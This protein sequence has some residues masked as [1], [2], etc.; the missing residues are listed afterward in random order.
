M[1]NKKKYILTFNDI[2]NIACSIFQDEIKKIILNLLS[3]LVKM[4]IG[5]FNYTISLPWMHIINII[6]SPYIAS[7]LIVL[8]IILLIYLIKK[9]R[10]TLAYI[11]KHDPEANARMKLIVDQIKNRPMS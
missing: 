9:R 3:F 4:S 11:L 10:R 7:I 2:L 8:L 6:L 5:I 1:K